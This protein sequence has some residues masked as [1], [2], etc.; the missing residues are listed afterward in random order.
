MSDVVVMRLSPSHF[1]V[2]GRQLIAACLISRSDKEG[3]KAILDAKI[4][5][6]PYEENQKL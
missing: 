3:L 5:E 2:D 4:H 1:D 6:G